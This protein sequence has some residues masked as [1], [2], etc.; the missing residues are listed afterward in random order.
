MRKKKFTKMTAFVMATVL[1]TATFG[2]QP[3]LKHAQTVIAAELLTADEKVQDALVLYVDSSSALIGDKKVYID[4]DDDAIKPIVRDKRAL[5]PVKFIAE[6][7]GG[8]VTWDQQTKTVGI[9]FAD[10]RVYFQDGSDVMQI[11]SSEKTE[12]VTMETAPFS[13]NGRTFVPIGYMARAA[14]K[15]V[16]YD[17]GLIVISSAK[18]TLNANKDKDMIDTLIGRLSDVSSVRTKEKYHKLLDEMTAQDQ[19]VLY[20]EASRSVPQSVVINDTAATGSAGGSAAGATEAAEAPMMKA[21]VVGSGGGADFSKTNV[22]VEGVDE[23]DIIKTDGTYMYYANQTG[24]SIIKA[25]PTEQMEVLSTIQYDNNSYYTTEMYLHDN[26]LITLGTKFDP[27]PAYTPQISSKRIATVD[28]VY[29][30]PKTT[31]YV[32]DISDKKQPKKIREVGMEGNF[33]TSRK[34]GNDLYF[35]TN[36]SMYGLRSTDGKEYTVPAYVD[37]AVGTDDL[38]LDYKDIYYFSDTA[39]KDTAGKNRSTFMS[40]Q[41]MMMITGIQ[42]DQMDKPAAVSSYLGAGENM[43]VSTDNM[44]ITLSQYKPYY[45]DSAARDANE[46]LVDTTIYKFALQDGQSTFLK[47]GTVPGTVL[48]KYAMD[49]SGANL[50]IATT[51]SINGATDSNEYRNNMYV[52]NERLDIVG[53]VENIAP[54]EVIRS[55]RFMGNRAYMVTFRLTDPLFAIDLTDAKN[56]KLLGA[57]KIPGYSTYLH[58]YDDTHLIGFGKDTHEEKGNA[59]DLGMKISMFDVADINEPKELFTETIGGRGTYSDALYND[60]AF[61]FSKE[62]NILAL[63]I[64][65]YETK[66]K[67]ANILDYG[68][69]AFQGAYF[70]NID[71]AKGFLKKGTVSHLTKEDYLKAGNFEGDGNRYIN[72]ILYIG[73]NFITLSND[74]VQANAMG[75]LKETGRVELGTT[76]K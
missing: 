44:Y 6:A 49:E 29:R 39:G 62:K 54:T 12:D 16:F 17:R 75:D 47:K 59:Y 28:Y 37:S 14:G 74:V 27:Q 43:Y 9:E 76:Q 23:G 21:T 73:D 56:P 32:Y 20:K 38:H 26:L 22:Q 48:N 11:V 40:N 30:E 53:K 67:T 60:K 25:V 50:R 52:L 45:Y 8:T 4:N 15:T 42:L 63:P 18:E 33:L 24:I 64:T 13:M 68:Q 72:R 69:F 31:V 61:L 2:F 58:P 41:N 51:A 57:L 66:D 19:L 35:V 7:C 55:V 36:V 10:K 34:I 1:C 71:M 70:Y 3:N 46:S 65:V 5:V